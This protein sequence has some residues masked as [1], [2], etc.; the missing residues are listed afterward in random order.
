MDAVGGHCGCCMRAVHV[1][2]EQEGGLGILAGIG[3]WIV[4]DENGGS[5]L[6]FLSLS[7][8]FSLSLG[9]GRSLAQC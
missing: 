7:L 1:E 6:V 8:R 5:G 4:L 3:V 2:E 9:R